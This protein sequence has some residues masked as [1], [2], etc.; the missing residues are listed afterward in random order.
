M[1]RNIKSFVSRFLKDQ[2]AQML[3]TMA[4]MLTGLLG[5]SALAVDIG[6]AYASYRDLQASTN[7][8]ALA[9]A[10][11]LPNTTASSFATTYSSVAGDDNAYNFMPNVAMVTGYPKLA[12]LTTLVNEG[13]GCPAPANA[14]AVVVMQ[15]VVVPTFFAGLIGHKNI[16]LTASATA[17]ATGGA[18]SP[19]NVAIILDTTL[20]QA[21]QDDNC[22]VTEMAC[23]LNGVQIL[24]K[25]LYPCNADAASCTI[26]KGVAANSVD[27]VSLFA[28]PNVSVGTVGI[29]TNCTTGI[30]NPTRTNGY[31]NNS[32]YGNYSMLPT[33][34][35]SG[36][37]TA[38]PYS[39]PTVGAS[40]YT[41]ASTPTTTPTYQITPYLSDYRLSDVAT[42]LNPASDLAQATGAVS[43]C[44]GII[45]PNFDGQYGT[46]YAGAIYAAQASLVAQ[47]AA[48]P[49]SKNVIILLSD[50]NATAPQTEDGYPSMPSPANSS[51]NYP[52]YSGECGQAV[53]AAK[54][55]TSQG[56]TV[57]SV[58]YGSP[59]SGCTTDSRA[60]AYPNITP[61]ETMTDIASS[62]ADFYS[63]YNQS[64]SKSICVSASNPNNT[65]IA[66]I[67]AAITGNFSK[68]RLIPN[69]TT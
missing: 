64:G 47:L 32:S 11:A 59:S 23:E 68:A 53:T 20:S 60:G 15:Q 14:N 26:T 7:A 16:T 29:Y 43:G 35:W 56:T 28:F 13:I 19:Y 1:N 2:R 5:M 37:P 44:G 45:P 31:L 41:P 40:N 66:G 55:A 39:Y 6:R 46:Y 42:T 24:L 18:S 52:S 3:P 69:G 38:E 51:G 12:C 67:F 30:P 48:N 21:S 36:V 17:S 4:L 50:G 9:G 65:S 27:R 54:Y 34:P 33:T 22:G 61:C 25:E 57:Y 63:D 8:A 62:P 58:A 10:T 49:G